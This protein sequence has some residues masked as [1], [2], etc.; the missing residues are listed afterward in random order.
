M[1]A[2][3]ENSNCGKHRDRSTKRHI[4][5]NYTHTLDSEQGERSA[6]IANKLL[7]PLLTIYAGERCNYCVTPFIF[8][9]SNTH[10]ELVTDD[11]VSLCSAT[12]HSHTSLW[13]SPCASLSWLRNS[14]K[15]LVAVGWNSMTWYLICPHSL[16]A[17]LLVRPTCCIELKGKGE[18]ELKPLVAS[19][20]KRRV[21]GR[22]GLVGCK[23]TRFSC[24][25]VLRWLWWT[26]TCPV[27]WHERWRDR[28]AEK[29]SF[30]K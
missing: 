9:Y 19:C 24:R 20:R 22:R 14:V 7:F 21:E 4:T 8:Y 11:P 13:L 2:L 29:K 18:A 25:V 6:E 30:D 1:A 26:K 15:N 3:R 17:L 28:V 12:R 16:Y 23:Q 5:Y 27:A 10:T